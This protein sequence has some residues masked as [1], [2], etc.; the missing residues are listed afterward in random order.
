VARCGPGWRECASAAGHAHALQSGAVPESADVSAA[1]TT[2]WTARASPSGH[3]LS[4]ALGSGRR[5]A[6][7]FYT[8][9]LAHGQRYRAC[10]GIAA[11][12][13]RDHLHRK[14]SANEPWERTDRVCQLE[15]PD[16]RLHQG[17][18]VAADPRFDAC[19]IRGRHDAPV[20]SIARLHGGLAHRDV[21]NFR[22]RVR[23]KMRHRL[24]SGGK[25]RTLRRGRR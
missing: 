20:H 1:A 6:P 17:H 16:A 8:N 14:V 7:S 22:R 15:S 12:V 2:R 25:R 19:N 5:T 18:G 23:R 24:R 4:A 13:S 10:H 21:E 3:R 11:R 9:T